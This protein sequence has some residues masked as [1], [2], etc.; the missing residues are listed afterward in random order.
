MKNP[1]SKIQ[2]QILRLVH[3]G[4][5]YGDIVDAMKR[6]FGLREKTVDMWITSAMENL[7]AKSLPDAARMACE[8][9]WID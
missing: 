7:G 8:R 3:A 6:D 4:S 5:G 9:G 2:T 1:L